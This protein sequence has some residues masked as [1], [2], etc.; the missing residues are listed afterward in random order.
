MLPVPVILPALPV[1]ALTVNIPELAIVPA[2]CRAKLTVVSPE[3]VNT[4][5]AATEILFWVIS[6]EVAKL[7]L[8]LVVPVPSIALVR[9]PEPL[10]FRVPS[11][12]TVLLINRSEALTLTIPEDIV[13]LF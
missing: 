7:L 9:S 6:W 5:A 2:F 11:L 13:K 1:T 3:V 12:V 4:L 8:I 10:K